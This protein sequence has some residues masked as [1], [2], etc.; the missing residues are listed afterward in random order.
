M[1][2][3]YRP[4]MVLDPAPV[5]DQANDDEHDDEDDLDHREPVLALP[6]SVPIVHQRPVKGKERDRDHAPYTRT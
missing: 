2:A 1:G 3:T 6:Y 4:R 5:I